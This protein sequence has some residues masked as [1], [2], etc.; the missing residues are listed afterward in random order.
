MARPN[1]ATQVNDFLCSLNI[2]ANFSLIE[3]KV[4]GKLFRRLSGK[5]VNAN[6]TSVT[7]TPADVQGLTFHVNKG[8]TYRVQARLQAKAGNATGGVLVGLTASGQTAPTVAITTT[9]TAAAAAVAAQVT[10]FGTLITTATAALMVE[11]DGYFTADGNGLVQLQFGQSVTNA[12]AATLY[13][14]S[15]LQVLKVG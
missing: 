5:T 11:V 4:L 2:A 10:A 9:A 14:G 7:A 1:L 13:R 12:T 6:V 3:K 15:W 8:A